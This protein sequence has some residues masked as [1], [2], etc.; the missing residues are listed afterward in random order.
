MASN[1]SK[2]LL[3]KLKIK[4]ST[5]KRLDKELA[6]YRKEELEQQSVVDTLKT[7]NGDAHDIKQQTA[8]LQE[9]QKMIL[10]SLKRLDA[11]HNDLKEHM[12]REQPSKCGSSEEQSNRFDVML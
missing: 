4:A 9:T 11:A 2:D 3:R 8:V 7:E 5:L 6:A 10:D 1:D 12:V